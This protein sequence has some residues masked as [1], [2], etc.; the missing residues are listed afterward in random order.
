MATA[1]SQMLDN[2]EIMRDGRSR[3]LITRLE[4]AEQG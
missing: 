2:A 1:C 4:V 3:E